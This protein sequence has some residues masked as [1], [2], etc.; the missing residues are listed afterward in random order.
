MRAL[1]QIVSR[2]RV[3]VDTAEMQ[4]VENWPTPTNVKMYVPSWGW[5]PTTAGIFQASRLWLHP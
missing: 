1:G 2:Q 3:G 5:P 4:A